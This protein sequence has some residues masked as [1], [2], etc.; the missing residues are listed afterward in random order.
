[1]Y[2]SRQIFLSLDPISSMHMGLTNDPDDQYRAELLSHFILRKIPNSIVDDPEAEDVFTRRY[3]SQKYEHSKSQATAENRADL[4]H[5][6]DEDTVDGFA[7][8]DVREVH[9]RGH[10]AGKS[11]LWANVK[12]ADVSS[13]QE[14]EDIEG[15]TV[16]FAAK[17]KPGSGRKES[18]TSDPARILQD[19]RLAGQNGA[20]SS[21]KLPP[22]R[23]MFCDADRYWFRS[24]DMPLEDSV[25]AYEILTKH[26]C[27]T[28]EELVVYLDN[29]RELRSCTCGAEKAKKSHATTCPTQ[30]ASRW[31]G[32][33]RKLGVPAFTANKVVTRLRDFLQ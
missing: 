24:V 32:A 11:G 27:K 4:K 30:H 8:N 12:V 7:N 15:S 22:L 6:A 13:L 16:P 20:S 29:H 23:E 28:A 17:T 26:R 21:V 18:S 2:F 19:A 3:E 33:L 14:L 10:E 5:Q 1:M 25:E 9:H 31:T